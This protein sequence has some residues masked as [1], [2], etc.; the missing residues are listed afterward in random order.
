MARAK[1]GDV[2]AAKLLFDLTG[3]IIKQSEILISTPE[4]K[5]YAG[6]DVDRV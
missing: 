1:K 4:V 6:I 5:Y 2:K 3:I